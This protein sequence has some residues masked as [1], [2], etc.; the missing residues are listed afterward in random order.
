MTGSS[1]LKEGTTCHLSVNQ[2]LSISNEQYKTTMF[3]II[4]SLYERAVLAIYWQP[5]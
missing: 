2:E 4:F 1:F 5:E 3:Q